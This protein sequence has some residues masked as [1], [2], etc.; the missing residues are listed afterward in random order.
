LKSFKDGNMGTDATDAESFGAKLFSREAPDHSWGVD[1][2]GQYAQQ[3]HDEI[4]QAERSSAPVY[5]ALGQALSLA[6]KQL[7]RGPWGKYLADLGIHKV[8]ASKARAIFRTFCSPEA[9][10][11]MGVEEA[12]EQRQ[13]RQA[14]ASRQE[15]NRPVAG[16]D[17]ESFEPLAS[18]KGAAELETFLMEAS[19]QADTLIDVAAFLEHDARQALFP[20]YHEALSR[21]QCLGRVLGV[22]DE[23]PARHAIPSAGD[24]GGSSEG[25]G[26]DVVEHGQCG[27]RSAQGNTF[28][29]L[30]LRAQA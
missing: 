8:R 23:R 29:K 24:S 13:R 4:L 16:R 5:W 11:E 2:L 25:P 14:S 3:R 20:I 28:P 7:G 15:P 10:A 19:S 22:E 9:V 1:D 6:R 21:L 27:P 18:Q 26:C 12:Y 30:S 17:E